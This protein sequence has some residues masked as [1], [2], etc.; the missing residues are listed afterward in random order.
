MEERG[1]IGIEARDANGEELGRISEVVTDEESG[2]V[3]HVLVERAGESLEV[4][5]ARLVLDPE[6]DFATVSADASDAEPGDHAGDE[7]EPAGYAP[8]ET[9][10]GTD[11]LRHEGQFVTEPNDPS[12][13]P[14][15]EDLDRESGEADGWQDEDSTPADSGYPRT[16][17]YIDPETGETAEGYPEA[18]DARSLEEAVEEILKDT[19]IRLV[20]VEDGVVEL[21]GSVAR[22]GELDRVAAS[23][24]EFEEVFEVDSGAVETG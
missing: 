6:A 15:Q 12:E 16:D 4:P 18:G 20:S 5:I 2:E 10:P 13:T 1:L 24:M 19:G 8:A 17:A 11:D 23:L 3:T 22:D 21:A 14:P 7:V 9:L